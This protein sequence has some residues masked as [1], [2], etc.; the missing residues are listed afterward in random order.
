[1]HLLSIWE[2]GALA[3]GPE[4][5]GLHTC[6]LGAWEPGIPSFP[7]WRPAFK[8]VWDQRELWELCCWAELRRDTWL[9]TAD[10]SLPR[11][12]RR[13]RPHRSLETEALSTSTP[14]ILRL[15]NSCHRGIS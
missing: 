1:M 3:A 14:A 6:R 15:V 12:P 5:Q 10:G 8:A 2:G 13:T 7:S 4:E 9:C 11:T